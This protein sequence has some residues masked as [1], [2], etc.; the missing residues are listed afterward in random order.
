MAVKADVAE[1]AHRLGADLRKVGVR[2]VVDDRTDIPF[3]RRAVDWELKGVPLRLELGPRDL[4]AG[5]VTVANRLSGGK[6]QTPLNGS[7][8][9]VVALLAREQ[10]AM[11][12]GAR[13]ARDAR[14]ADVASVSEAVEACGQGWA[15]VPWSVVGEAGEDLLAQSAITVRC[16][17]RVDGAVPDSDTEA[18]L[19]AYVARSY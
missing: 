10:A 14:T 18:D 9:A 3:G 5:Q 2:V 17:T 8:E 19:I 7:P 6:Q 15:R 16:L 11:L 12:D 13:A 1:A 4:V